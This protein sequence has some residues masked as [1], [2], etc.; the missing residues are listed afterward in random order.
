M[1]T[2]VAG[3][4]S[5]SLSA[6]SD[7]PDSLRSSQSLTEFK[8]IQQTF[9]RSLKLIICWDFVKLILCKF[10]WLNLH[11]IVL[12]WVSFLLSNEHQAY[13]HATC[14]CWM[15]LCCLNKQNKTSCHI[16]GSHWPHRCCPLR[17]GFRISTAGKSGY[18]RVLSPKVPFPMG[19]QAQK[20]KKTL[21]SVWCSLSIR[22]RFW[23]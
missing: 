3:I 10:Q 1:L 6:M 19:I 14:K 18:A 4:S 21:P 7:W 5:F 23:R 17:I 22:H 2:F 12:C 13:L 11:Y 16:N 8:N 15:A 9:S 20:T